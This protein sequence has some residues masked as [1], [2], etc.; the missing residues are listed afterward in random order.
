MNAYEYMHTVH[1]S[2]QELV[3]VLQ[4]LIYK[5]KKKNKTETL[6]YV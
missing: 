3:T 2:I 6:T 5:K 1:M 4:I